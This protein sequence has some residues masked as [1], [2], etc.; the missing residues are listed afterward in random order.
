MMVFKLIPAR[1]T[2]NQHYRYGHFYIHHSIDF[3][4]ENR[5]KLSINFIFTEIVQEERKSSIKRCIQS[6]VHAFQC[7]EGNCEVANC[8]RMKRVAQH[9]R[10][11][12]RRI[13]GGCPICKQL[14]ALCCHHARHCQE[15]NCPVPI[16]SGIK[17]KLRQIHHRN[18]RLQPVRLFG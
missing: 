14:V 2:H 16:C 18:R 3:W 15:A 13:T 17:Q 6:L 11:C 5:Q 4:H 8:R 1:P 9:I 12:R 7:K 10:T